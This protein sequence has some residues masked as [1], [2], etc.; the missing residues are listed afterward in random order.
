MEGKRG[1]FWCLCDFVTRWVD[2]KDSFGDYDVIPYMAMCDLW[3]LKY[4][5]EKLYGDV[6]VTMIIVTNVEWSP[7]LDK[8]ISYG[9]VQW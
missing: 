2:V 5:D 8:W 4:Y 6:V 7:F 9:Y 3:D 1:E